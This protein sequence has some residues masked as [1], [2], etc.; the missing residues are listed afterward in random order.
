MSQYFLEPYEGS[1]GN[2]K[3]ELNLFNYATKAD[4]KEANGIYVST[5]VSE[6]ILATLK[7]KVNNLD[8]D[9]LKTVPADLS[10][11]S[12]AVNDMTNIIKNIMINWLSKLILL[13]LR[14]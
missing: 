4:L 13:I 6:T 11:P 9:K 2:R 7:N 3:V 1:G 14:Y 8:V 5:L 12:N 10:K